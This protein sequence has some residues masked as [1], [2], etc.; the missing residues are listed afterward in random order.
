M[1]DVCASPIGMIAAMR[2]PG[3]IIRFEWSHQKTKPKQ[4][5][6]VLLEETVTAPG[7]E[8]YG[9]CGFRDGRS[10]FTGIIPGFWHSRSPK[11]I[12]IRGPVVV[13]RLEFHLE[14]GTAVSQPAHVAGPVLPPSPDPL[15]GSFCSLTPQAH[16]ILANG[17]GYGSGERDI[18]EFEVFLRGQ[19]DGKIDLPLFANRAG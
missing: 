3:G 5:R 19:R 10:P 18:A 6:L 11:L 17:L 2:P 4:E 8:H 7:G 13:I 16:G 9:R 15:V 14:A 12:H 1:S